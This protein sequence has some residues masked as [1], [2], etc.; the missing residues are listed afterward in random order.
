MA[1]HLQT[2]GHAPCSGGPGLLGSSRSVHTLGAARGAGGPSSPAP[3]T[4]TKPHTSGPCQVKHTGTPHVCLGR[5]LGVL[6]RQPPSALSQTCLCPHTAD[7]P[8]KPMVCVMSPPPWTPTHR[9][10]CHRLCLHAL[11]HGHVHRLCP[12]C[13]LWAG[14]CRAHGRISACTSTA[15]QPPYGH[16]HR[17]AQ[18]LRQLGRFRTHLCALLLLVRSLAAGADLHARQRLQAFRM[19]LRNEDR[20]TKA[21]L[22]NARIANATM[23]FLKLH[24]PAMAPPKATLCRRR[25]RLIWQ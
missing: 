4:L 25:Q 1:P 16:N 12:T 20:Y 11:A 9:C 21:S 2:Q 17:C 15:L 6:Y 23:A 10:S 18:T 24:L 13:S 22:G 7:L 5:A 14:G 3:T 19:R 8:L